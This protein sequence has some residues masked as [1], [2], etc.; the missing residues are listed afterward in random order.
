MQGGELRVPVSS[1]GEQQDVNGTPVEEGAIKLVEVGAFPVLIVGNVRPAL[2]F[3]DELERELETREVR[4]ALTVLHPI[5]ANAEHF[6]M[7]IAHQIKGRTVLTLYSST[8]GVLVKD[9]GWRVWV[10]GALP[11]PLARTIRTAAHGIEHRI[12]IDGAAKLMALLS[13][14]QALG[15]GNY[16]PQH[17]V[18]GA[19]CGARYDGSLRWQDPILFLI[20]DPVQLGQLQLQ[21]QLPERTID[22]APAEAADPFHKVRCHVIDGVGVV[23]SSIAQR[24]TLLT[25]P[26]GAIDPSTVQ[27]I[28]QSI[29][30]RNGPVAQVGYYALIDTSKQRVVLAIPRRVQRSSLVRVA[31]TGT[32]VSLILSST[33]VGILGEDL[34]QDRW[35]LVVCAEKDTA[36]VKR[37]NI[38]MELDK[39]RR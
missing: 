8:E 12:P 6:T 26:R 22:V 21:L 13:V 19:M 16:L 36:G 30:V 38:T 25:R 20:S 5:F 35:E 24:V 14:M 33:I 18:G 11:D 3:C 4:E 29:P 2:A 17:G 1:F 28:L 15:I 34:A 27:S 31:D 39:P 37:F 10:L 7:V 23:I 32:D 9:D